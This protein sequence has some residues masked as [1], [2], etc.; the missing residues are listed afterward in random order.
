MILVQWTFWDIRLFEVFLHTVIINRKTVKWAKN[1]ICDTCALNSRRYEIFEI[2]PHTVGISPKNDHMKREHELW[3]LC[4]ELPEKWDFWSFSSYICIISRKTVK[5]T[6]NTICDTFALNTRRYEI[7]EVL[8]HTVVGSRKMVKLAENMICDT[9]ALNSRRYEIFEVLPHTLV[10][11]RKTVKWAQNTICDTF[12]LN[13]RR[14]VIIEIL[15]HTLVRSR[16]TVN[17]A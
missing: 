7:F 9:C 2:L 13:S 5:W 11:S 3:Y 8:L 4:T 14:S 16:K 1:T 15:H 12:A 6:Q 10:R 17:W